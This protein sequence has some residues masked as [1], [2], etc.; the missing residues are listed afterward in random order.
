[1]VIKWSSGVLHLLS[2]HD[3]PDFTLHLNQINQPTASLLS[4]WPPTP[5]F[6]APY[7]L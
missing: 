2:T 1:M 4:L 3:L 6:F 5:I 7:R